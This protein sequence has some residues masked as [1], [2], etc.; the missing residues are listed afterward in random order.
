MSKIKIKSGTGFA[1]LK[2][3][4]M[5]YRQIYMVC[6][7]NVSEYARKIS[8]SYPLLQIDATEERKNMD[9]VLEICRWLLSQGA[10][11]GAMV[12]AIGGGVTTDLVGFAASIYMRGVRYA[13]VPTTLLGQVDAGIGGKTG[14]NFQSYK[15]MLGVIRQPEFTWIVSDT[16]KTLPPK[17]FYSGAAELLKTF[18]IKDPHSY[19]DAV[20][21]LSTTKELDSL[22][23]LIAR[24]AKIKASIVSRDE[25][26]KGLR[27]VLNLGHTWGHAIEWYQRTH[28]GTGDFSHGE[29]V[30][31]GIIQ[32]AVKSEE[33]KLASPGLSDKLKADF[34]ACG[35]P[36]QLPFPIE[37]L[38]EAMHKDKKSE[39]SAINYVLIRR[40]GKVTVKKI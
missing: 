1:G 33:L 5:K 13:N 2:I 19:E 39:D 8:T 30:A 21:V 25:N 37:E 32:A 7:R 3:Q 24:A 12:L 23:P 4:L 36:T 35:L 10:D 38:Q 34:A 14:V 22:K 18:I 6:D 29:A 9:Q 27:R 26:E 20:S 31:I 11:R 40:I 15:N 17:Q 28:P 16:L